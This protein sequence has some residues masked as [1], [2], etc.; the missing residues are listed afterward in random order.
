M[1]RVGSDKG[2]ASNPEAWGQEEA[3][4]VAEMDRCFK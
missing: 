1:D 2:R 4:L 3:G